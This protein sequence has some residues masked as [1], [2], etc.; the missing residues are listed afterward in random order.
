MASSAGATR[1]A[2]ESRAAPFDAGCTRCPRLARALAGVR[3][4]YPDYYALPLP[5]FGVARPK[6]LVVGLAPG[7]HGA[8]RTGRPFTGDGAGGPLYR[9]LHA[10]GLA[11]RPVSVAADDALRLKH[12][13]ITNA[14]RCWPPANKPLPDEVRRCNSYLRFDLDRVPAGGVLLALGAIAHGAVLRAFGLRVSRHPFAHGAEYPMPGERWLLDSY[15]CSRYNTNTGRLTEAQLRAV[16]ERALV[17]L[18][19]DSASARNA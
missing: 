1:R 5:A 8:N 7:M 3:R 16:F 13:A 18:D 15:H 10:L 6:L 14:V 2:G 17:L 12:C 4:E 9:T 19:P 11:N